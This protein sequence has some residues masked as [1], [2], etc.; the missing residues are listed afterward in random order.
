MF[1]FILFKE[2]LHNVRRLLLPYVSRFLKKPLS[3]MNAMAH[4]YFAI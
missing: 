3:Q 2:L 4:E 1:L